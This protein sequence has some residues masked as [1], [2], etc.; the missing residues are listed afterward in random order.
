[1]ERVY[2]GGGGGGGGD[3]DERVMGTPVTRDQASMAAGRRRRE[4]EWPD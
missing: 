1:M 4:G 2:C 3:G